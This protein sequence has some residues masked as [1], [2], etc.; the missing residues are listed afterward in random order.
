[1]RTGLTRR[2]VRCGATPRPAPH[3]RSFGWRAGNALARAF[4]RVGIGPIHLLTTSDRTSGRLHTN[5]VVLV[6]QDGKRFLVAPYG[7]VAWVRNARA[8]GRVSLRRGR[9]LR[10]YAVR[11][12]AAAEAGPVLKRYLAVAARTG[13]YFAA[14]KDSPVEEFVAEADRHPVFELAP[15]EKGGGVAA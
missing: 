3:F 10:A 5:P 8:A 2:R 15:L 1:M 12:L 4:A 14:G 11:E 13:A 7:V 9:E 6:E